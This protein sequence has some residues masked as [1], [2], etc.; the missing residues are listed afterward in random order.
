M[1]SGFAN[2][3]LGQ[4]L[5]SVVAQWIIVEGGGLI[6]LILTDVRLASGRETQFDGT[7]SILNDFGEGEWLRFNEESVPSEAFIEEDGVGFFF[8]IECPEFHIGSP[9]QH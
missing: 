8:A 9:G 1:N 5:H 4:S 7:R 6:I 2:V 3:G